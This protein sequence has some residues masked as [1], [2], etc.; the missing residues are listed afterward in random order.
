MKQRITKS[1]LSSLSL[2]LNS[3]KKSPK[4]G[5]KEVLLKTGNVSWDTGMLQMKMSCF[6]PTKY[7]SKGLEMDLV[8]LTVTINCIYKF[9]MCN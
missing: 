3:A 4:F 7:K 9:N 2:H 8:E 5:I 6:Y 1:V